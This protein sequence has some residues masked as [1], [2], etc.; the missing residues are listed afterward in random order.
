M[1][2]AETAMTPPGF[3]HLRI[4]TGSVALH[5]L[6]GG[7]G[8]P[9]VLLAGW[10]QTWLAWRLLMP[11]LARDFDVLAI[12]MRGQGE[13]DIVDGPYDTA[14]AAADVVAVLDALSLDR[15]FLIGHDVGAW[16]AFTLARDHAGR[17]LGVGLLDA[18]IPG[19][20]EPAFFA[21]ANAKK[22]WQFY[23]HAQPDFAAQLVGGREAAYLGWYFE[24]KCFRPGTIPPDIVAAY[25]AAYSRPRAMWAGFRWYADL[26]RTI[27]ATA[28][29]AAKPI[30]LPVFALGGATATGPLLGRCLAPYCSDLVSGVVAECGHYL[31][32]EKPEAVLEQVRQRFV[33]GA[34]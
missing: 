17:L 26:E 1:S 28:G 6:R 34:R 3:A 30:T 5:A 20:V 13:S 19:L 23:F 14:T 29:D 18:A 27:A 16:I 10:P 33:V 4:D 11:E 15:A 12:E 2:L 24:H 31:P 21:P 9:L 22:V 7:S 25:V 32:E 8:P